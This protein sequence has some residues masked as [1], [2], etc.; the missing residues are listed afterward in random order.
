[1]ALRLRSGFGTV[2]KLWLPYERIVY[3]YTVLHPTGPT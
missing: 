2:N 1:M 3:G